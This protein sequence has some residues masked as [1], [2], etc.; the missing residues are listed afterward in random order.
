MFG[1]FEKCQQQGYLRCENVSGEDDRVPTQTEGWNNIF[2]PRLYFLSHSLKC[3]SFLSSYPPTH[4]LPCVLPF[5]S[6]FMS[7][8]P[9]FCPSLVTSSPPSFLM[10]FHPSPCPTFLY[11][12]LILP[13]S[14]P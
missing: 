2:I 13:H 14:L 4:L 5:P 8:L 3:I 9:T 7:L 1:G 11:Y 12:F 6:V 10:F